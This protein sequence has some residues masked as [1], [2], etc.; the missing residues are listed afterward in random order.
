MSPTHATLAQPQLG[1]DGAHAGPDPRVLL[2]R[3]LGAEGL[4][5]AEGC[6]G[7]GAVHR[8]VWVRRDSLATHYSV[9]TDGFFVLEARGITPP[10]S[11]DLHLMNARVSVTTLEGAVVVGRVFSVEGKQQRYWAWQA[12][13]PL[14]VGTKLRVAV[15][16]D[17]VAGTP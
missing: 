13:A 2:S 3:A 14:E 12:D 4:P 7:A 15:D 17:P 6:S 1:M 10:D 5:T 8:S 16:A 11:P 9:A